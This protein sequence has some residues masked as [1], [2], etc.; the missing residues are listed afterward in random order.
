MGAQKIRV[1]LVED[2][3]VV[4]EGLRALLQAEPD[5]AVAGEAAD[6]RE[7]LRGIAET[8]PDVVLMDVGLPGLNGIEAIRVIRAAHPNLPV[9]VLSMYDDAQ[10]VDRALRAGAKGYVLKGLG[11]AQV[12]TAIRS[13]H[14]GNAFL[15]PQIA[16]CA[17][18]GDPAQGSGERDPLSAREREVVQLIAEGYTSRQIADRLGLSVKTVSNHRASI[19]EKLGVRTTAGLVRYAIRAGIAR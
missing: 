11:V 13:V 15:S 12:C 18:Q 16:E 9:L 6:G 3:Q 1:L 2:H 19:I 7:A 8:S 4:R 10:T 5:I 17:L 14:R